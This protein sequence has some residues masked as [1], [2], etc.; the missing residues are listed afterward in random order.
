MIKE[1]GKGKARLIVSVTCNGKRRRMTKTVTYQTKRELRKMY[2]DFE[3]ECQR[4][5][6]TDITIEEL[7]NDQIRRCKTLNLKGHTI[8]GYKICAERFSLP[9]RTTL[10][11]ECTTYHIEK[12]IASMSQQKLSAKTI[13]NT[14]GFLS[15]SFNH[16]VFIGQLESNP[17]N[18]ATLP[19]GRPRE[20]RI[21]YENE[22]PLFIAALD[23]VCI[24]EKVA[25]ELALF[26]G[27]RR[28]EILGLK[29]SDVNLSKG[30]V[31]I[32]STRHRIDGKD[33]MQDT[34]TARSTRTLALPSVLKTDI[35]AL[36]DSHR[37]GDVE[38]TD[39]LIQNGFGK[40]IGPQAI[41][42]RLTR[43]EEKHNLPKVTLH[44]LR[45]TCASLLHFKGVDMAQIS[46]ELGHSNLSTTQNI[47]THI[48]NSA[49]ESSRG[50]ASVIDS[51]NSDVSESRGTNGAHE[52]KE[53]PLKR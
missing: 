23:D 10:A 19:K 42:A 44:G 37:Q 24:D 4:N 29:E 25:Y 15:A 11:K 6:L 3:A 51:Y 46:A 33:V 2:S 49:S 41:A 16:A 36:F 48:F 17:C 31:S 21:L 1:I 26:L 9:F 20:I 52:E 50:I 45:H 34:K 27:L 35:Y 14:I 12:E 32:H 40:P 30:T 47:Y 38:R 18:K 22:I 13:K 43:F 7:L 39:Y 53:E 8:R 28:S 5:P